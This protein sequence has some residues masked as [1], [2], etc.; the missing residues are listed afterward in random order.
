MGALPA[1]LFPWEAFI[2]PMSLQNSGIKDTAGA[3]PTERLPELSRTSARHTDNLLAHS[4]VRGL[5]SAPYRLREAVSKKLLEGI[6][7]EGFRIAQRSLYDMAVALSAQSFM[8][9]PP[10]GL[11]PLRRAALRKLRVDEI[12]HSNFL[13]EQCP[14]INTLKL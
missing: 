11:C 9:R 12:S 8:D 1:P 5:L 10:L 6:F 2:W 4:V 14:V 13:N 3:D 7:Q